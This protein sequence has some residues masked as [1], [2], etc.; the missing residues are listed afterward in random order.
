MRVGEC[1]VVGGDEFDPEDA[2]GWGGE[3]CTCVV[4]CEEEGLRWE[5]CRRWECLS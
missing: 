2:V 1:V 4:V 3:G 5:G